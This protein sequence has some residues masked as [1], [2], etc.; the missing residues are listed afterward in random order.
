MLPLV[1][2]MAGGAAF[3]RDIANLKGSEFP[4]PWICK[5]GKEPPS[6][7]AIVAPIAKQIDSA[8]V[9]SRQALL[10]QSCVKVGQVFQ[11]KGTR[12]IYEIEEVDPEDHVSL[13]KLGNH[14]AVP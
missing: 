14:A 6:A 4:C 10:D 5:K 2:S 12:T 1:V 7:P 3:A 8:G 11:H 13:V 9:V